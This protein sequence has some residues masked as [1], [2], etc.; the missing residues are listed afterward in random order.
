MWPVK[1]LAN[2]QKPVFK[3]HL[4]EHDL[5]RYFGFESSF[6]L[7]GVGAVYQV[8]VHANHVR[9]RLPRGQGVDLELVEARRRRPDEEAVGWTEAAHEGEVTHVLLTFVRQQL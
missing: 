6:H 2:H 3:A 7:R 1:T 9:P 4:L 8:V 5:L